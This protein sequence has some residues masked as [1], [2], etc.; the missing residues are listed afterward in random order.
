MDLSL[1][2]GTA[3]PAPAPE[4]RRETR[5]L[6]EAIIQALSAPGPS[7]GDVRLA[8][9]RYARAAR[10]LA[11]AADEMLAGIAPLV[12]R[13]LEAMPSARRA[14][15]MASVEWWAIHGYYGAD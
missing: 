1:Q 13:A 9:V 7:L 11:I 14:E 3:G 10:E 4:G 6:A 12:R 8:V 5:P 15:L 2:T